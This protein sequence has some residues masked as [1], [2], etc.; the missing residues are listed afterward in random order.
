MKKFIFKTLVFPIPLCLILLA[1]IC[2]PTTPRAS[3]SLLI[4]KNNKD[5]L[6]KTIPNPRIIFVGGSNLSFGLNSQAIKD[7][8]RLNPINTAIHA[9]IG[10]KF[11]ID[12]TLPYIRSGD[13]VVLVPEYTHYFRSL[14][15]GSEELLR[16]ILDI[17][18]NEIKHLNLNQVANMISFLPKYGLSKFKPTEYLNGGDSEIYSV[19]S[20]NQYGDTCTHWN[21]E[22]REFPPLKSLRGS[23]N[24]DVI[25]Y[26]EE[27]DIA[28]K[29][30]GGTLFVSFPCLQESS[31]KNSLTSIKKVDKELLKSSLIVIGSPDR[32]MMDD[33]LMFNTPWHLNKKGVEYR[34]ALLINDVEK[35]LSHSKL[36]QKHSKR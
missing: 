16:T 20:F 12:N 19:N 27:F 24:P 26:F 36:N 21:M 11:M 10:I 13:V 1:G 2:L 9:S 32:Y 7:S 23:F 25:K 30:R 28:V 35:A 18:I 15:Y 17:D 33:A 4:S 6:L 29:S 8:L 14:N 3:K 22:K 34:S 5:Y 31:F